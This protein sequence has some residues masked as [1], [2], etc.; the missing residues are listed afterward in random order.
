MRITHE[1]I[2]AITL[3]SWKQLFHTLFVVALEAAILT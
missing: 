1:D 2:G 3:V